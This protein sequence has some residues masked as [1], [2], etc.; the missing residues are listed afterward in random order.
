MSFF[1]QQQIFSIY[2]FLENEYE[3]VTKALNPSG[4]DQSPIFINW[5]FCLMKFLPEMSNFI[6]K[7]LSEFSYRVT[8]LIFSLL[9]GKD[10]SPLH[11]IFPASEISR[12][13]FLSR[14]YW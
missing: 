13:V 10:G 11:Q 3:K 1:V 7:V 12:F 6:E 2:Q 9:K 4:L 8:T 14:R 5:D